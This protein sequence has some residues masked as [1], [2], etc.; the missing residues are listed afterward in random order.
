MEVDV[1]CAETVDVAIELNVKFDV[2]IEIVVDARG[3]VIGGLENMVVDVGP[4]EAD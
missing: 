1:D 2:M 3:V 4:D